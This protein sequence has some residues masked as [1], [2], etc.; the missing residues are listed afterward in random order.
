VSRAER[1]GEAVARAKL[2]STIDYVDKGQNKGQLRDYLFLLWKTIFSTHRRV[3][4]LPLF[5]PLESSSFP[6][7]LIA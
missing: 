5:N 4:Y 7:F 3:S 2:S 6:L 1:I